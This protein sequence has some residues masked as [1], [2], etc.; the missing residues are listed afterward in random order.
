MI[1]LSY[2]PADALA[3]DD[4]I[5]VF[6]KDAFES[7]D[8]GF[9][10]YALGIVARAKGLDDRPGFPSEDGNPTLKT[11]LAVMQSLGFELTAKRHSA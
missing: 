7:C 2:D 9:I 8:A 3:S 6:L 4:A 10:A 5:E 11:V 1:E